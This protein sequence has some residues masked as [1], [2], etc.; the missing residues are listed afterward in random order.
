MRGCRL[1]SL[2]LLSLLG[3][4]PLAASEEESSSWKSIV[5]P[6]SIALPRDHGAHPE[7]RT[8]W[9]YVTGDLRDEEGR[10]MG[11][12]ITFFRQGIDASKK[13]EGESSLR[14]RH[15]LV[16]HLGLAL[17]GS[18][19]YR[20]AQRVRRAG[21]GLASFS[22]TDLRIVLEDWE[23]ERN[24]DG[25]LRL[26][27]R[28]LEKGF[29]IDLLARP[30]KAPVL[31]GAGG[32]SPKGPGKGNASAYVS[33]SRMETAGKLFLDGAEMTVTGESWFDHEWGTSQ[34][35]EGV[36]GWDW[37]AL[38]LDNRKELMVYRLRLAD[39]S[40]SPYSAGTLVGPSG[41]S[42]PISFA[43]VELTSTST[44]KSPVTGAVYPSG[45]RLIIESEGLDLVLT[46]RVKSAELD[47]RDSVGIAYWEGPV[48]VTGSVTGAGFV[49]LAGYAES[50]EG[51]F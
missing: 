30:T 5:P 29:G 20:Q 6:L 18:S 23:M 41:K 34:L 38:R 43:D 39:G 16:G 33:Y 10:E 42:R 8:E 37:F 12:Q 13:E 2:L 51:R 36:V 40:A 46:P 28:D 19:G 50:L 17:V 25:S 49:E 48:I 9:W 32:L 45:W 27:A 14:P 44:W 7:T 22:E 26:L 15:L 24:D 4:A 3:R 21:G 47:G 35:G 1:A 31:H 11:Y